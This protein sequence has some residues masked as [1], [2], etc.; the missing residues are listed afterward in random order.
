MQHDVVLSKLL[1]GLMCDTLHMH[2]D[3]R[4]NCTFGQYLVHGLQVFATFIVALIACAA[5]LVCSGHPTSSSRILLSH[6]V[7]FL[8][9]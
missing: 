2:A 7:C 1:H 8:F 9:F 4:Q 3:D 5:L 6:T